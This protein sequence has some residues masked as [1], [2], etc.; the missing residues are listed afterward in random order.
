M[1]L[2]LSTNRLV[3]SSARSWAFVRQ[4]ARANQGVALGRTAAY[5]I[6]LEQDDPVPTSGVGEP[7]FV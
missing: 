3:C 5:R 2:M 7:N 6:V 4:N 1:R